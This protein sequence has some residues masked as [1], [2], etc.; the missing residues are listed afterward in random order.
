MM[1][2]RIFIADDEKETLDLLSDYLRKEGYS[3]SAF[4]TGDELLSAALAAAP[5]LVV[6]DIM[7]PGTDGLSICSTLRQRYPGLPVIII[8]ARTSSYDRVAGLSLGCNEY[9]VKPFL[10]LE[11]L[12]RIRGLLKEGEETRSGVQENMDALT[13][14]PLELLPKQRIAHLN[15]EELPVSPAEFDFLYCLME[16]SGEAVSRADLLKQ[17][18][19]LTDDTPTRAADDLVKRLRKKLRDAGSPV[20]IKTVWGYGFRIILEDD[21]E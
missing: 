17:I 10:P 16:R 5:D 13:F 20:R 18:W 4:L 8:S 3:V 21:E 7:M 15:G 12:I 19:N 2:Q 11:L 14:G 9:I 6:L 1:E